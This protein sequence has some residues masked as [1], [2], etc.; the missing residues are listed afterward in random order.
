MTKSNTL[1]PLNRFE[2]ISKHPENFHLIERIPLTI[3]GVDTHFPIEL[4]KRL[5]D[6]KI[7]TVVFLDTETTGLDQGKDKIIELGMVKATYSKNRNILLSVD[8][9]YDEFEDPKLPIPEKIKE[10]TGITDDM[11][12]DRCFDDASVANFLSGNPLIIAHNAVFDRPFFDKRFPTLSNCNWAD[13]LTEIPWK[14]LGFNGSKLEYLNL[15]CGYFYDAHRAY[16]DCLALLWLMYQVKESFAAL[17]SNAR[18]IT[19]TAFVIGNTFSFKDKLKVEHNFRFTTLDDGTKCWSRVFKEKAEA[20]KVK[21]MLLDTYC[22]GGSIFKVD[23]KEYT[24]KTRFK[25]NI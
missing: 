20:E 13:S 22:D 7:H 21:N 5:P 18:N 14:E 11:V 12:H 1:F 2:E 24:P 17:L 25:K 3:E 15:T 16:V 8:K 6:D 10:L 19:Y 9:Y 23:I 4:N